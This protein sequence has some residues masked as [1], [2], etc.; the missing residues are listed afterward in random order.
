MS[1]EQSAAVYPAIKSF[2]DLMGV[3]KSLSRTDLRYEVE[4]VQA[5][6]QWALDQIGV[7]YAVGDKVR[8]KDGYRM[9]QHFSDGDRNGWWQYRECL[10]P[11]ATA[12]VTGVDF[13]AFHRY[14][15]ASIVLDREW[16][17]G[18]NPDTCRYDVRHWHGPVGD[19]PDGMERP[20]TFDQK[21]YPEGRRHTFH[22]EAEMLERVREKSPDL[23]AAC[24]YSK[25]GE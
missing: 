8:I 4:K 16:S 14:W 24:P 13:N 1:T 11:G 12:T 10:V 9:R 22:F 19:T 3:L 7:D 6:R 2:D 17:V 5:I 25:D 23:C 21:N 20:S 15:Y 18:D